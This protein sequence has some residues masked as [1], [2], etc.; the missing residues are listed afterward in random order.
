MFNKKTRIILI[1]AIVI[2]AIIINIKPNL[3]KIQE[4]ANYFDRDATAKDQEYGQDIENALKL[5]FNR[6]E[7]KKY[8]EAYDMLD[9]NYKKDK[10]DTEANFEKYAKQYLINPDIYGKIWEYSYLVKRFENDEMIYTYNIELYSKDFSKEP[11]NPY[12]TAIESVKNDYFTGR[13]FTIDIIEKDVY[14]FKIGL[15][16]QIID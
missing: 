1:I 4:K 6:L 10:F 5:F 14:D 3:I 15:S 9:E 16:S 13:T 2:M 11:V 8:S 12:L 7:N